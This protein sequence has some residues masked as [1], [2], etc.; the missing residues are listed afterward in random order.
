METFEEFEARL[1]AQPF[2]RRI[3]LRVPGAEEHLALVMETC[4]ALGDSIYGYS[5]LSP[6]RDEKWKQVATLKPSDPRFLKLLICYANTV[7]NDYLPITIENTY[8]W[9]NHI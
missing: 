7:A 9:E 2:K 6:Y 4:P 5:S 1:K 8:D 3:L